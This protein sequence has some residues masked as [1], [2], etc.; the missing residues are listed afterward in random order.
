MKRKRRN[1][2]TMFIIIGFLI[3]LIGNLMIFFNIPYSKTMT[4]SDKFWEL[5]KARGLSQEQLANEMNV[6]RQ[7]VSKWESGQSEPDVDKVF[8]LSKFFGVTTDYLLMED[9]DDV[10]PMV[11]VHVSSN[12][13]EKPKRFIIGIVFLSTG[14]L[15]VISVIIAAAINVSNTA[16]WLTSYPS[17]L[18][19]LIFEGNGLFQDSPKGL[20]LGPF[21]IGG[22]IFALLGAALLLWEYFHSIKTSVREVR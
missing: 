13:Q 5:R 1:R 12:E 9:T 10:Q 22:I 4:F 21:F 14:L 18:W 20:A 16:G 11:R 8:A 19:F 15:I 17:K 6:S 2:K 3:S 7:A